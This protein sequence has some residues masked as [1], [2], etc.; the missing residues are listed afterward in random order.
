MMSD[1][2][3]FLEERRQIPIPDGDV[4]WVKL[5][6][7]ELVLGVYRKL[8]S[9][10]ILTLQSDTAGNEV[11]PRDRKLANYLEERWGD[12]HIG[13]RLELLRGHGYI[14]IDHYTLTSAAFDL[15]DEAEPYNVFIS[16]K[17]SESSALALLVLAR[18]KAHGPVPFMDMMLEPGENWHAELEERIRDC[19]YFIILLGEKTLASDM[20]VKEIEWAIKYRKTIIPV[21]HSGFDLDSEQWKDVDSKVKEAIQRTN[22]IRVIE[23]S[24]SD[25]NRAIV[26]LLNRFGITP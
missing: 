22:A 9:S 24:A 2:D 1:L 10:T 13:H 14:Y 20:T 19:D 21:W 23:E 17:R 4:L 6:A 16:Y 8:W 18:L 26:E 12:R 7:K 11:T 3:K 25:Y 5:L 15:I